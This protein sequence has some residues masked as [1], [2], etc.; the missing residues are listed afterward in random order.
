VSSRCGSVAVQRR[1]DGA[2]VATAARPGAPTARALA[3]LELRTVA[4]GTEVRRTPTLLVLHENPPDVVSPH[5]LCG[6]NQSTLF[7]L[8]CQVNLIP[9]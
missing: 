3:L 2:L 9:V 7:L 1:V 8:I 6:R 4:L 5:P